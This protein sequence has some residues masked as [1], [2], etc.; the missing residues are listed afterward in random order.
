MTS[1]DY[2]AEFDKQ[3]K[4]GLWPVCVS[5]SGEGGEARFAA[6]FATQEDHLPRVFRSTGTPAVAA[7]DSALEKYVKEPLLEHTAAFVDR[8]DVPGDALGVRRPD[9]AVAGIAVGAERIGHIRIAPAAC[10]S[11]VIWTNWSLVRFDRVSGMCAIYRNEPA[12]TAP[13]PGPVAVMMNG[14]KP[15]VAISSKVFW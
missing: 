12:N 5:A 2:Q 13:L 7:I 3:A 15:C 8:V 10:W 1:G 4:A 6:I 9:R 14:P 11:L